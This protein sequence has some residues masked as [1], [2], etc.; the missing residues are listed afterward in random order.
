MALVAVV[1]LPLGY[2]KGMQ[3]ANQRRDAELA[4]ANK[5]AQDRAITVADQ[6][7]NERVADA[8]AEA[9]EERKL[10]DAIA[11]TPDTAP[12]AVRVQLGCQRLR[13]QG[14]ADADLPAGCG[15]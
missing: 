1:C 15:P 6:A 5:V 7:A 13:S 2:C 12:D 14:T 3:H 11:D 4:L 9:R 10:T 8:I